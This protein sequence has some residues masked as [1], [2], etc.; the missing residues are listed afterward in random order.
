M[1]IR[2]IEK[3]KV[4]EFPTQVDVNPLV[5]VIIL[6]HNHD[7]YIRQCLDSVLEQVTNFSV[8]V[9]VGED[10]SKDDTRSICIEYAKNYPEKIRLFLHHQ[11][12]NIAING[13]PTG[14]FN[15]LF[16]LQAARGKYIALCDG[17]DYWIDKTKLQKQIGFLELNSECSGVFSDAYTKTLDKSILFSSQYSLLKNDRKFT[18]NHVLKFGWFIPS[19]SLVFRKRHATSFSIII[20]EI[21]SPDYLI[22]LEIASKGYI[23]FFPEPMVVYRR[24]NQGISHSNYSDKLTRLKHYNGELNLIHII[25]DRYPIELEL[26]RSKAFQLDVIRLRMTLYNLKRLRLLEIFKLPRYYSQIFYLIK[27]GKMISF[28]LNS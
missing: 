20:N 28:L 2:S 27:K 26:R 9:I 12:N 3:K 21:S 10:D 19:A 7:H 16:N 8:E 25:L 1:D 18:F 11:E 14:R 13:R 17:D 5:S 4:V 23:Y 15:F 24:E 6:A 22:H